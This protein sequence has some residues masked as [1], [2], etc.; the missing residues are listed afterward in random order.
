MAC[1]DSNP[2]TLWLSSVLRGDY[3]VVATRNTNVYSA[4]SL[5]NI[6]SSQAS[7]APSQWPPRSAVMRRSDGSSPTRRA[8]LR[9]S[10]V[11][12]RAPPLDFRRASNAGRST[13]A[14]KKICRSRGSRTVGI[15]WGVL[16]QR[17]ISSRH[18]LVDRGGVPLSVVL[19][20]AKRTEAE[21]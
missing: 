19:T 3:G 4:C 15:G 17:S 6:A 12:P 11:D 21:R 5:A 18:L 7:C 20:G 10:L 2:A 1:L 9:R 8:P 16:S 13:S 14:P